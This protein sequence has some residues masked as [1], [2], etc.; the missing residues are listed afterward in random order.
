MSDSAAMP[1][2]EDAD[3]LAA[4][5]ALG[6]LQGEE[7]SVAAERMRQDSAFARAVRA[8]QEWLA[9]LAEALT[10]VQ[11]PA[12][13]K[14]AIDRALPG[15]ATATAAPLSRLRLWLAGA[16]AAG[17]VALAALV[18]VPLVTEEAPD[19]VATL[20]LPADAARLVAG[21]D[22]DD[23]T[24]EVT[25]DAGTLP[26]EGDVEMWW[27]A[28]GGTPVSLGL[29]PRS[30]SVTRPLPAGATGTEGITLA[31]S[32]EPTGGSP[33]GQPTTVLTTAALTA[34]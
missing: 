8:W 10:P 18:I 12:S 33:N 11:P 32:A 15:A 29:A 13:V 14:A 25:L 5:Y 3:A 27:I 34:L 1:P 20:N 7:L 16:V 9:P 17:A 21:V 2:A 19:Q 6:L 4:E 30:G 28:P 23:R 24:I 22:L 26:A 31:L